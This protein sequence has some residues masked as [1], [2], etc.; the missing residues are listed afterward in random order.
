[1][2]NQNITSDINLY[3]PSEALENKLV[4]AKKGRSRARRRDRSRGSSRSRSRG[5]SRGRSRGTTW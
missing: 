3:I 1:M 4:I 5:M 2:R